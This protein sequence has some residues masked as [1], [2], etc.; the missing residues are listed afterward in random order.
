MRPRPEPRDALATE[1]EAV[2]SLL[3]ACFE[4]YRQ[5]FPPQAG[6]AYLAEVADVERR[7]ATSQ[8]IVVPDHDGLAGCV[9]FLPDSADDVHPWPPGGSVL[10]LLAVRPQQ[11]G[12]GIGRLLTEECISRAR[13]AGAAFI[14][15]HTAPFMAAAQRLYCHAG[16]VR[17]EEHDFDPFEHYG[18]AQAGEHGARLWGAAYVLPLAVET[19]R[20]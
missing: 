19:T 7:T 2:R 20:G 8:L 13:R 10:R 18:R 9:T 11:R 15:L 12:A 1:I 16:F 5:E 6:D 17:A 4:P 14:G 3:T